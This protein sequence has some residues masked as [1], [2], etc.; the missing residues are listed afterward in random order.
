MKKFFGAAILPSEIT[1]FERGYL[2]RINR[3]AT[4]FYALHVP[5][6]MIIAYFNETGPLMAG[7]LTLMALGVP[8]LAPKVFD[9]PRYV[10][11]T[12]GFT[13]MIVG[14][15]LV[16][17]GQGPVQIEMHFYFFASLAMLAVF[18]NPLV[19]LTAAVT[20]AAHHGL[21]W[22]YLPV[23]VFNYDAPFYVVAIHAGFVVLESVATCFIARSF[24]DN[25]IGLEKIVQARTR[26]LDGR[27]AQMRLVMDHVDQGF[28]TVTPDGVMAEER[29]AVVESF[30]GKANEGETFEQYL[31][32]SSPRTAD[33]LALS[34]D[35][36][37]E[38]WLPLDVCL[39][40]L[41]TKFSIE[42]RYFSI[43]YTPILDGEDLKQILIVLSDR[44]SEVERERFEAESREVMGIFERVMKDKAG[45][46]EFFEEASE[47]VAN[48]TSDALKDDS[49]L[50]RVLHTLKGNSMMFGINT[51]G[52][53]CHQMEDTLERE[54]ERPAEEDRNELGVRWAHL[55]K[56]LDAMLGETGDKK[57]EVDD[58][59]YEETLHQILSDN[60][61]REEVARRI[62][63][64][65]LEHTNARL[66]RVAEQARS[67]AKRLNKTDVSV[68]IEG[69]D[70][71]LEPAHWASFW[72][73]FVHVIRNA[74]DHGIEPVEERAEAGKDGGGLIHLE[75]R[76]EGEEFVIA[77]NDNGRGIDWARVAHKAQSLGLPA[78]NQNDLVEAL[79]AEGMS[80]KQEVSEYSGRGV[81]M[82]AVRQE[83][84]S[85]HGQVQVRSE[86][87][88]GTTVEF[89]FPASEMARDPI[90]QARVA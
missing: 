47:H 73:S 59:E 48:I 66:E 29:S 89:R 21:L 34:W 81:G 53:L 62:A 45:F 6:F 67:I 64:W 35:Q 41:P 40:Q 80:T 76:Q 68:E 14:G 1:D 30:L 2:D 24:F 65:K 90:E 44:T 22:W 55:K 39:G 27:N 43:D 74:I 42:D 88:N 75:T 83:C 70:L 57:I 28:I 60:V 71:L 51:V 78:A 84:K 58:K 5:V 4:W 79:F 87:G 10:S 25:V 56:N 49:L 32:R 61:S 50:K 26:A 13:A 15:L 31:H 33:T 8:L 63:N 69:S 46:L 9:N 85:R 11:M 86:T 19:I 20:V 37:S 18:A 54:G 7:W 16:H 82:G 72:A 77:L 38:G 23:S 36:L 52:S 12:H 17:F 3:I